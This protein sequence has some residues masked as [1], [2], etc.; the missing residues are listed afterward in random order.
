MNLFG[1]TESK[2]NYPQ[3][4]SLNTSEDYEN[5]ILTIRGPKKVFGEDGEYEDAGPTVSIK[6]DLNTIKQLS[7]ALNAFIK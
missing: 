3:Y 2:G 6:L 5:V 7:E 1:Y 4:L